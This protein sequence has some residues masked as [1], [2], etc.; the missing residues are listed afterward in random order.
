MKNLI[1][2]LLLTVVLGICGCNLKTAYERE[3]NGR[4]SG[5]QAWQWYQE[6]PWLVGCNFSPSTAINQ[7]EMW[8]EKTFDLETIDRELGW[9]HGIG[10]NFVRVY[11]HDMLWTQDKKGF[12]SRIEKFLQI[13]DKHDMKVMFVLLDSCWNPHPQLGKQPEPIPHLH[14]SGWVQSP[15]I[16]LMKDPSRYDELKDYVGGILSEFKNDDRVLLWDLYNEPGHTNNSSYRVYEPKNKQEL[17]LQLMKKLFEW[18]H[19]VDPSQPVSIC[20]WNWEWKKGIDIHPLNQYALDHS[21][22]ITFHTYL[23][24]KDAQSKSMELLEYGRPMIC[25]E[26]M[27]RATGN[28]FAAMLPFFKQHK[29][30]AC[31]W[32][33]VAGKTQTQYPWES[34]NRK[35]TAEP[36]VW[37]HDIFR[38]DG[39]PYDLEEVSLIKALSH[40]D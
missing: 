22:I 19:E 16:D 12:L 14:N 40:D 37:F 36:K 7:L 39:T 8:Q 4:W 3:E 38:A 31:N 26:Y 20:V 21:D 27:A 33:F 6:Q 24:P 30:G 23:S 15:H 28:T 25:T 5:G 17:A 9:V 29:I 35:F 10:M 1:I 13:A 34:W 11:L 2:I 18:V 32:G